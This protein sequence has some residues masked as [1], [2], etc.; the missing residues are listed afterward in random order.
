MLGG[1]CYSKLP[2]L[3]FDVPRDVPPGL[4]ILIDKHWEF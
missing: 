2:P 1:K 4:R 3:D